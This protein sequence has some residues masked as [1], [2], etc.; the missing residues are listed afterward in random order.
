MGT[1]EDIQVISNTAGAID[2]GLPP[3]GSDQITAPD[4]TLFRPSGF[5][6]NCPIVSTDKDGVVIIPPPS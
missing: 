3:D 1:F 5:D 4:G 2:G 6:V